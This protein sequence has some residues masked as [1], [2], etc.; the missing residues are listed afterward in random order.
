M[1]PSE[2]VLIEG[3]LTRSSLGV[4]RQEIER[5]V[6]R[7]QSVTLVIKSDGGKMDA[8]V[9]FASWLAEMKNQIRIMAKIYQ[10]SSGAALIALAAR[11]RRISQAGSF[12]LHIGALTIES[13]DIDESGKVAE[14]LLRLLRSSSDK[15]FSLLKGSAPRF[16]IRK[17]T[18]LHAKGKLELTPAECIEYGI[19]SEVF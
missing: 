13:S 10:A 19:C 11:E 15:L 5:C 8:S 12:N 16:P 17:F 18:T 4:A 1:D 2:P 14:R 6:S 3:S 9:E 7:G